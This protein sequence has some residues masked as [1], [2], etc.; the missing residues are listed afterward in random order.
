MDETTADREREEALDRA[1]DI[2]REF[3]RSLP[4]RPVGARAT[5][6]ELVGALGGPL[7][8]SPEEPASVVT[9]LARAVEPGLIASAQNWGLPAHCAVADPANE[10]PAGGS[11]HCAGTL[12]ASCP[13]AARDH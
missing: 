1:R 10:P 9:A 4:E 8:E 12:A 2:A 7:P 13:H 6:E 5:F 3:F 11:P